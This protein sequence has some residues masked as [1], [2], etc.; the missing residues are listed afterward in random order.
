MHGNVWEWTSECGSLSSPQPPVRF[1][2]ARG[3]SWDNPEKLKLR[4]DYWEYFDKLR[5]ADTVGFRL[6]REMDGDEDVTKD[7]EKIHK[8]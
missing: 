1:C 7:C 3:G 6:V 4:A 5:K 8:R 2:V